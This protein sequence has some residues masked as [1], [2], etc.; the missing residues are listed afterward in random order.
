[1]NFKQR[2]ILKILNDNVGLRY[3]ELYKH[4]SEEDKFPYHLKYLIKNKYVIKTEE[5][6]FLTPSG[7]A[8]AVNWIDSEFNELVHK[9]PRI[10]LICKFQNNFLVKRYSHNIFTINSFYGLP[11]IKVKYGTTNLNDVISHKLEEK[12]LIKGKHKYRCM[13][14]YILMNSQKEVI[15]D[16]LYLVFDV[17]VI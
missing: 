13:Q 1:M 14:N 17:Q 6:Y 2:K 4:F 15:V 11:G 8:Y 7:A 3:S 10:V 5:K 9:V 12:F 16:F